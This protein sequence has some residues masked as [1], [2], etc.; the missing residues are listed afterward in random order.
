M[1][2]LRSKKI[3][4]T[5][6]TGDI[7]RD[8]SVKLAR[9][10]AELIL[11][12]QNESKLQEQCKS[13]KNFNIKADYIV[14]NFANINEVKDVAKIISEMDDIFMIINLA[15]MMSFNSLGLESVTNIEKIYNINCLAP[16]ILSKALLPEMIKN[17][18]GLIVNIGSIFGSIAF[19]YFSLYS[20]TK[21]AIRS[22][23]ESLSRELMDSGVDVLY[24]APR[25]VATKMNAGF[26]GEYLNKTKANIDSVDEV[27]DKIIDCIV[28]CKKTAYFGFPERFFVK[29]N[30]L[31]PSFISNGIRKNNLIAREIILNNKLEKK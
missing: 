9:Q 14:V 11:I 8:I 2:D 26:I 31:F 7:G 28:N 22:F 27:S 17:K 4:I 23:S 16:I 30:Y 29:L 10:K 20:S 5:G 1:I 3:I 19:P 15:G 13:L 25:A 18:S 21:A 12:S 24:I 6:A